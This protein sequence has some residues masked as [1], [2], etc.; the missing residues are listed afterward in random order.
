M[1]TEH[2]IRWRWL[3]APV[4]AA[5]FAVLPVCGQAQAW[6][7]WVKGPGATMVSGSTCVFTVTPK[8]IKSTRYGGTVR[9]T[10]TTNGP[11]SWSVENL[12]GW[13]TATISGSTVTL[14]VAAATLSQQLGRSAEILVAKQKV[15]VYQ[16]G[17]KASNWSSASEYT[18]NWR[19][20]YTLDGIVVTN[21]SWT[22]ESTSDWFQVV[23]G[24]S[25]SSSGGEVTL[26]LDPNTTGSSRTSWI[27]LGGKWIRIT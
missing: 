26:W 19:G 27:T 11:C 7:T 24:C 8:E 10:V 21:V 15:M 23:G 22:V 6:K 16:E 18:Y 4:L 20:G 9:L 5:L 3:I 13:I 2:T 12:P 1:K 14:K 25:G 17:R